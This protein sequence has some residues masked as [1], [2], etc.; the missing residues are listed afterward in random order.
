MKKI[1]ISARD[2]KIGGIEKSL[3][4]LINYLLEKNEVTLVL[5]NKEGELLET[6]SSKVKIVTYAPNNCKNRILRKTINLFKRLKFIAFY[7]RKFDI[8]ISYATYLKSGAFIAHIASKNSILWCHADYLSLFNQNEADVKKFFKELHFEKFSKIVFVS[9][10]AKENFLKVFPNQKNVYYCNNL[11]NYEEILVKSKEKIDL[12][13]DKNLITF[14]NVGRH[15]EKQKR[16]SRIIE[17]TRIL[18]AEKFNFRVIF[19]GYGQDIDMYKKMVEKRHLQ[20]YILFEGEKKNPYPYF[21]LADAVILSSEYEGYPVV[22][23]ESFILGKPVIT[24]DVADYEDV[25][26]GKG[27]VVDKSI[28]GI[29]NG[30]KKFLIEG[31]SILN[32]FNPID[33]NQNVKKNLNKIIFGGKDENRY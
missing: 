23:L 17:A 8:S 16:L 22:F 25:Q 32:P 31:Y 21:N 9:K 20:E 26:N 24:T 33:F 14:L 18:K 29:T 2:L 28:Q 7:Y 30:M 5:E 3:V 19:V 13:Y 15:D 6:L 11:I 10:I 12:K 1:L 4:N 27:I